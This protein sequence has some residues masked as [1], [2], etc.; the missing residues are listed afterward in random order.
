MARLQR[1]RLQKLV[2]HARTASPYY[3]QLYRQ[4]PPG[5]IELRCLPVTNKRD[6]MAHFDDWVTDPEITLD[7]LR[8]DLLVDPALAGTRYLGRY[9]V[10][11][12]SGTSGHPAVVV[13]DE[14]SWALLGLLGRRGRGQYM[15]RWAI[16]SAVARRG[17]RLAALFVGGG[18]FGAAAA[19]ESARRRSASLARRVRLFDVLRPLS[20]LVAE[21]NAFQ[22]TALEGYP[23]AVE[24]LAAEQRA[25][26]L[27]VDPVLIFTAGEVLSTSV[28]TAVETTFGC[29]IVNNYGSAEFVALASQCRHGLF[30][31]NVDW[32]LFE[33]V[34]ED[35]R[36]VPPGVCS[37]TV[38]VTNL[39]NHVQPMIRYDLGDRVTM[40]VEPCACGNRLPAMAV[41]GRTGD[42]LVFTAPDGHAVSILPLALVTVVEETPGVRRFQGIRTGPTTVSVRLDLTAG[43]DPAQ[44]WADVDARLSAYLAAQGVPDVSI[45]HS[46]QAPAI[47]PK[48][49]K[50]RQVWSV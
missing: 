42:L 21:L 22:P 9:H 37:H 48:T 26:R 32:F 4:V 31:V 46:A 23:S 14:D 24:L 45:E 15:A 30:H 5:P 28:R 10:V 29:P 49:G 20:D 50:F 34:D 39:A 19:L 18:H 40:S 41:E 47:D 44:V 1:A 27:H 43:A 6:L 16:V 8:R 2:S 13:H 7:T 36:P 17:L 3:R 12:T 33:P 38:L 25:G 35:C 11:T